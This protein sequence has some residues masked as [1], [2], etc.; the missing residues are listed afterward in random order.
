MK[1]KIFLSAILISIPMFSQN[2]DAYKLFDKEGKE[3]TYFEM[4]EKL[5]NAEFVFFGE[6][7]NNPIS[8]W[9]ELNIA[10]SLFTRRGNDLILGA[11]IFEAD[12]QL[13]LNE[14]LNDIISEK[15]FEDE[16]KLWKNYSTDYKPIVLYAK[17]NKIPFIATNVPRRYASAVHKKDFAGLQ[18]ISDEAKH[19]IAPLPILWNPELGC[20][21]KM[22]EGMSGMGKEGSETIAKAQAIKDATMAYFILRNWNDG[23]I[24]FHFNGSYHSENHEG[25][26]WYIIQ[27]KPDAKILTITT[28]EQKEISFLNEEYKNTADFIICIREDMTKTY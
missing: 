21:K 9:L 6:L 8:H 4:I 25:I 18:N 26:C 7:H 27:N 23:N 28:V 2:L 1:I 17:E 24:F 3:I 11:E 14:Y 19:V 12:N 15:N 10:K 16:A 5:V 22:I 20:Y 13:I